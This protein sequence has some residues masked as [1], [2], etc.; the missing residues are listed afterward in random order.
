MESIYDTWISQA[1]IIV[2]KF[3]VQAYTYVP[4]KE[5]CIVTREISQDKIII[6]PA[7]LTLQEN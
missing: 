3:L 4:T 6:F 5:K 2:N 7:H 1:F